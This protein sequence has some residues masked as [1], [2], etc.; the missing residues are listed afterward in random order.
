MEIYSTDFDMLA[1][2]ARLIELY[3]PQLWIV[4]ESRQ[5]NSVYRH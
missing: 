3:S 4:W 1:D 2:K 5:D